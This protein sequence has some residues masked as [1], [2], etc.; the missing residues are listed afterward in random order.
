M[1]RFEIVN[2]VLARNES[3]ILFQSLHRRMIKQNVVIVLRQS[4]DQIIMTFP[5]VLD[6]S[7]L[8]F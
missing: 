3:I 6:A 8:H 7:Y 2:M 5:S 1:Q 4:Y